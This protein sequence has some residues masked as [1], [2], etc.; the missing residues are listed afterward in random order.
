MLA[1]K[2]D[3]P[4]ES[5][6]V[7]S[8]ATARAAIASCILGDEPE[9]LRIGDITLHP[10]QC[11]AVAR[12]QRTIH[13]RGG[14]LLCD[15]VGLGKTYVALAV[16]ARYDSVTVIAPAALASMWQHA[17]AATRL[18]VEFS[19]VEAL[20]RS[21]SAD[22]RRSLIV[23]DE[24]HNFRNSCTRRYAALAQMCTL[25]PVLLLTAT[26]LHTSVTSR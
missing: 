20:G 26:P 3:S 6:G 18:G 15:R 25:A 4:A 10:H 1:V 16:A 5:N 21:G 13:T 12:I 22:R 7:M 11:S 19:S 8:L 24:A 9:Q 14:A 2:S 23:V 17:L